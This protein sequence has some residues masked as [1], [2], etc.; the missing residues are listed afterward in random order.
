MCA[1]K[2]CQIKFV[3]ENFYKFKVYW[4]GLRMNVLNGFEKLVLKRFENAMRKN[5]ATRLKSVWDKIS[6]GRKVSINFK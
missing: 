1:S 5:G 2:I 3:F 6:N 4:K